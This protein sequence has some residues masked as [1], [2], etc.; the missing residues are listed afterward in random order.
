MAAAEQGTA[1]HIALQHI[2]LHAA[3][4]E[5][6]VRDQ[7][8]GMVTL[9]LLSREQ[10]DTVDAGAVAAFASSG[11]GRRMAAAKVMQREW[12][13]T[14]RISADEA[15]E[16]A[17]P[18]KTLLVQ[19]VMDACF[20][21]DGAWVLIDFKTDRVE[22][23]SAELSAMKHAGQLDFYARALETLTSMPVHERWVY[24]LR[25]NRGVCLKDTRDETV[26]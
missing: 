24:L 15:V 1:T 23:R 9:G 5:K 17:P 2:N 6:S 21:E 22:E 8:A 19:G 3:H 10:A 14:L 11:L 25:A 7:L 18:G 16:D 13:F 20:V 26:I 4:D 12:P